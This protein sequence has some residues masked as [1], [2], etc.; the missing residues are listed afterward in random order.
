MLNVDRHKDEAMGRQEHNRNYYEDGINKAC[1]KRSLELRDG[2]ATA[3]RGEAKGNSVT[4]YKLR[5]A[6]VLMRNN[7]RQTPPLRRRLCGAEP[8]VG[9]VTPFRGSSA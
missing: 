4:V 9:C 1:N 8:I 2:K 6:C 7:G 3:R 5:A